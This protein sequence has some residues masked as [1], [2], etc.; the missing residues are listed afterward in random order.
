MQHLPYTVAASNRKTRAATSLVQLKL[1]KLVVTNDATEHGAAEVS[2]CQTALNEER[3]ENITH[4]VEKG[5]A[6]VRNLRLPHET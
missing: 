6:T 1:A 5:R 3:Y 2:S 4:V